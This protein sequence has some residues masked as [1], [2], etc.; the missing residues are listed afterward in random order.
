[1]IGAPFASGL[2]VSGTKAPA[3]Y[4]YAEPP[5]AVLEKTARL[6]AVCDEFGVPLAAAALQFVRAHPAVV[7]VIPGPMNAAQATQNVALMQW[8][9]PA[10]FWERVRQEALVD[11][12]APVPAS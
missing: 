12:R 1:M 11:E 4:D 7:S 6:E 9:I 5:A 8:K 10:E 2:L 3:K